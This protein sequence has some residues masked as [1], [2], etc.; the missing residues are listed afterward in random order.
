MVEVQATLTRIRTHPG[1]LGMLIIDSDGNVLDHE[2]QDK[3]KDNQH[4]L[5]TMIPAL[6]AMAAELVRDLDPQNQLEFL[7]IR[8]MRYEILVAHR[9]KFVLIVIQ[10]PD[11]A[12]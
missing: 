2:L 11:I 3:I 7:R 9:P 6:A 8:S 10:E 1:V 12:Q 4:D 5:S